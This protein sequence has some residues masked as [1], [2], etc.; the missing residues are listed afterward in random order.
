[1][2]KKEKRNGI[3]LGDRARLEAATVKM[4]VMHHNED[5]VLRSED[6]KAATPSSSRCAGGT[7]VSKCTWMR[8]LLDKQK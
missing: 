3:C 5:F 4:R 1:L 2:E 6:H 7:P 8:D